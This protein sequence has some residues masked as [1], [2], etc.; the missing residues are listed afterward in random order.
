MKIDNKDECPNCTSDNISNEDAPN[1][2]GQLV[3]TCH[4]CSFQWEEEDNEM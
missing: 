1:D 2:Y 4:D 3:I